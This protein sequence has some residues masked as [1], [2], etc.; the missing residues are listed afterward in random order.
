M[1]EIEQKREMDQTMKLVN[2]LT[3]QEKRIKQAEK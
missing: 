1:K 3:K 2:S